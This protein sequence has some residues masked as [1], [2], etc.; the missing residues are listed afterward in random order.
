MFS[1][2]KFASILKKGVV[3]LHTN[4][5]NLNFDIFSRGHAILHLAVSV[6]NISEFRT[7]F[8]LV[9]SLR[10]PALFKLISLS[11]PKDLGRGFVSSV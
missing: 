10:L 8:T 5:V 11:R 2:S 6:G 1:L 7:V 9:M 4:F 3:N